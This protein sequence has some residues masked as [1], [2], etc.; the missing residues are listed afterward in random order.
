MGHPRKRFTDRAIRNL[1]AGM[2]ADGLGLYVTVDESGARRWILRTLVHGKRR[3]MGLGGYP[4]VSLAEAREEANRFRNIARK[5]G[6]PFAERDK[7]RTTAP[8]FTA[9]AKAVH[10]A[11]APSWRNEKHAAQWINTLDEYVVPH[12]GDTRVDHVNS[13][14]ILKALS[15]IWLKKPETARRVLQRIGT[16]MNWAKAHRYRTDNPVEGIRKGL[17][18]Q[19]D[20]ETHHSALPFPD[21]P[22]FIARLRKESTSDAIKLA[23]EF[24]I[25]TAT[26]TGEVLNAKW[27]EVNGEVWSIP[28]SR[29][30]AKREHR[31]PLSA[32]CLEILEQA[33]ALSDG[34]GYVFPS[35]DPD[36]PLSNMAFLMLLRRMG[37]TVTAHGFRSSFRD[38]AA[39]RTNFPREVCEAALAHTVRDAV[40]AAYRR[41]D[42]F[43]RRREL[44]ATWAGFATNA[45]ASVVSIRSV[46]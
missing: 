36:K 29:M 14:D 44:M 27:E 22:G 3:E 5:G 31:V 2:H 28:A 35:A 46:A 4:A 26:R 39:E 24:L 42:L 43:E 34:T 20:Q 23:F 19:T 18:K 33:R 21:V 38:W 6:D 9:A 17:P 45:G 11:H 7:D 30:K 25:L 40:E 37:M 8:T 12:F 10:E 32:R 41:T 1:P 13:A 15:P 16:V